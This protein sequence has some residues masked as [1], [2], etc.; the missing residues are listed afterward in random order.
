MKSSG[1]KSTT[2]QNETEAGE[3]S[4]PAYHREQ[5]VPHSYSP[6][7]ASLPLQSQNRRAE[8]S[9]KEEASYGEIVFSY[10]F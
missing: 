3:K 10:L 2:M 8:L 7:R 9:G 6:R 1:R 4:L 5:K